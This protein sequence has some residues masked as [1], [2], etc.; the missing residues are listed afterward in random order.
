VKDQLDKQPATREDRRSNVWL[1]DR[2]FHGHCI[3]AER[4]DRLIIQL[5]P[6]SAG[7]QLTTPPELTSAA[8]G[9]LELIS[10][11]ESG[12]GSRFVVDIP[13]QIVPTTYTVEAEDDVDGGDIWQVHISVVHSRRGVLFP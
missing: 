1:L 5:P 4:G 7:W 13:L 6:A 12:L 10:E 11:N 3:Q 9:Q 8:S 2:R